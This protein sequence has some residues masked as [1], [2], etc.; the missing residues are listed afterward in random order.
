MPSNLEHIEHGKT[1]DFDLIRIHCDFFG[2]PMQG[3]PIFLSC[4]TTLGKGKTNLKIHL[5]SRLMFNFQGGYPTNGQPNEGPNPGIPVFA[6]KGL[7]S[8]EN[9]LSFLVPNQIKL[10]SGRKV[11]L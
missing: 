2:V 4:Q 6:R 3:S 11:S 8:M 10:V 5:K 1:P 9:Y 7:Y